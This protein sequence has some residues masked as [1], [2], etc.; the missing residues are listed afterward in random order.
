MVRQQR[1]TQPPRGTVQKIN[2]S[3][4]GAAIIIMV[5]TPLAGTVKTRLEPALSPALCANLAACF[6]Q[7]TLSKA[8]KLAATVF[9]A[10]TPVGGEG[11]LQAL[12]D[13][14]NPRDQ[15]QWIRQKGAELGSRILACLEETNRQGYGPLLV[16]GTD[17]PD[18]PAHFLQLA[19][20]AL[21]D[22]ECDA[23]I[24]PAQDGGYYLLGVQRPQTEL[25]QGISWSTAQVLEQTDAAALKAGL[26]LV[27]LPIW[28]DVDTPEDLENLRI[29]LGGNAKSEATAP[30]TR[31]FLTSLR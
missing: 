21:S 1:F 13:E 28:Y 5:K 22:P 14:V 4:A 12:A 11:L 16:V 15:V 10:Y 23:V 27:S 7:D 17:S 19:L 30:R 31:T 3:G 8:L 24:G 20:D 18:L 2:L 26:R 6:F 9:V 25:L 29:N